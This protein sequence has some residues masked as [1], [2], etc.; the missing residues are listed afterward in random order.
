MAQQLRSEK[1]NMTEGPIL[2]KMIRFTIPV[3]ASGILQLLFNAADVAVVGKFAGEAAMAAVG[4]CGAL[5]NLIINLFIGLA[6]GAGVIAAPILLWSVIPLSTILPT[7]ASVIITPPS[8]C[9]RTKA[10]EAVAVH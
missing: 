10:P 1:L 3:M 8:H 6:V 2:G 7:S 4:S 5:I 9:P